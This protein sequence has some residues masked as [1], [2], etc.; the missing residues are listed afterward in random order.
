MFAWRA[1]PS[2]GDHTGPAGSGQDPAGP[3]AWLAIPSLE[4][5][6]IR[7]AFTTR[8][9]GVSAPP[10]SSLN[11]SR[12]SGDDAAAVEAN[13]ARALSAIGCGPDAW[14]ACEQVHGAAVA[15]VGGSERGAGREAGSSI[16]GTDALWTEEAGVALVIR[17]ADCVPIVLADARRRRVGVVHAGWRGLI[18]G[19]VAAAVE[20]MG[21]E[22]GITACVGPA[23][24]PCCYEVGEDVAAPARD[25]FGEEIIYEG[26]RDLPHVDLWR[27]T[28]IALERAGV[29][30]LAIAALCT[31]CES[32]RFFSHRAGDAGR[33]GLVAVLDHAG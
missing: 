26:Y 6:G 4:V 18:A 20:A 25:T 14:T 2:R 28:T 11:L 10:F 27:A 1:F 17:T 13:R 29:T 7:V 23:I 21:D 5:V 8:L 32:H 3:G 19:V 9:G 22:A 16:R 15:Q 31:K 30:D 24:G 12:A 33:H